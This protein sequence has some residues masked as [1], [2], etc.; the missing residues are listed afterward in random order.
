MSYNAYQMTG[1][2]TADRGKLIVM[3]Y[4]H[5]IKWCKKATVAIS[6]K[7][8]EDR[9]KAI[10]KVQDGITELQCA[11]DFEKGGEIAKNLNNLY[12]FFNRHLSEANTKNEAKNVQDVQQMMES[13]LEA[14]QQALINV[15]Q[16]GQ[17]QQRMTQKSYISM[18]G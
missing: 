3:I 10:F 7:K 1:I 5:C 16:N 6:S 18:V 8:I 13:L 12:D 15:R 2:E 14:W 11:L 4:E 17:M 9:T